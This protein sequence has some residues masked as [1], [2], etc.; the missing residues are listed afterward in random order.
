MIAEQAP[1]TSV[2]LRGSI[3]NRLKFNGIEKHFKKRGRH[4]GRNGDDNKKK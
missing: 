2:K 4:N 3:Q 1:S